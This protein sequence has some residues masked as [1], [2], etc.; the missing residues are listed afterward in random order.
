MSFLNSIELF[1]IGFKNIGT[2]VKISR[3]AR[4]NNPSNIIIGNNVRIDDFSLLSSGSEP[5]IIDNYIH[6]ATGVYI[7]GQKGIH[8]KSYSNISSGTKIYT[9]SDSYCGNYLIGP[10][11]DN[12]Y[13]KVYGSPLN[14]EKHV[15]IGAGSVILPGAVLNEGVAIG[16]NSLVYKECKPWSIYGGSPV[17]FLKERSRACLELEKELS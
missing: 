8:I 17:K 3:F 2:N 10:T 9:Q 15:I 13:R 4:I 12:K 7:W 11:V 16:S 6:I 5:F 1:N 14:I